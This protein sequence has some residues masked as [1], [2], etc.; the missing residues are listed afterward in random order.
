MRI[1]KQKQSRK[2][3]AI[4]ITY[5]L[6]QDHVFTFERHRVC[7]VKNRRPQIAQ[8]SDPL[9]VVQRK[10]PTRA[11]SKQLIP[12]KPPRRI[13]PARRLLYL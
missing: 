2:D 8:L 13:L 1:P 5:S 12:Q 7:F 6:K 11:S 4:P 10:S 3:N 9:S